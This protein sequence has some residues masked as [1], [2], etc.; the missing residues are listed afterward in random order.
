MPGANN[1]LATKEAIKI[2]STSMAIQSPFTT[3]ARRPW[4][5]IIE[6]V[7]AFSGWITVIIL[8]LITLLLFRE[9]L[10]IFS[11]TNPLSFIFGTSWYPVSDPPVFG[12]LPFIVSSFMITIVAVIISL[13][14]GVGAAVFIAELA[15]PALKEI[16]KP[17]VELLAGI[18]SIVL[19]FI[20]FTLLAPLVHNF[21]HLS[22]GLNGFTASIM[23]VF[24]CLP[25]IISISEDAL[26]AV[27]RDYKEAA[28]ALGATKWQTISKVVIPAASSGIIA[29]VMLGIGRAIGE[30]MTVLMVSGGRLAV[31]RSIFDPM[32]PMPARIAIEINNA[33]FGG[34]QYQALFAMGVVLFL[35]TFIINLISDL[36][37]ERQRRMYR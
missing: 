24:I 7:I 21:F 4:E 10:P 17:L 14:I 11:Y 18:P 12:I 20:G 30:T 9:G 5:R 2:K 25:T 1:N 34:L 26:N 15:T 32:S 6:V 28:Y 29:S 27:P 37:L 31:P 36:V 22:T 13:P 19:G 33:V 35:I 23:L 3:K 16:I 8:L